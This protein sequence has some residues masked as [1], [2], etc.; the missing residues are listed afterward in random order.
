MKVITY[1]D[2]P[3]F[4]YGKLFRYTTGNVDA[5]FVC[6]G[7]DLTEEQQANLSISGIE[8]KEIDGDEFQNKMQFLKFKLMK[9]EMTD[10]GVSFIDFDTVLVKDWSHVFAD[11]F[12][13]GITVRNS[14]VKQ[15]ILRAYTNGG[16]MF[17]KNPSV[18]DY[19]IEVM[20]NGGAD[21]IPEYDEIFKSLEEG[22][23]EH[24]THKRE[25]LRWWV[26]QVFISSLALR[27]FRLTGEKGVKDR[28]FFEFN[29]FKVGLFSCDK[30]NRLDPTPAQCRKIMSDKSAHILHLKSKGR[31]T[32]DAMEKAVV[33]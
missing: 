28:A 30:Y 27:Y 3:Y 24:K 26:D 2:S 4:K 31:E 20:E 10:E 15:G 29:G 33:R 6:Y 7:P 17:C 12:D 16:V 1:S 18:C 21:D 22:R 25:T 32:L 8:H 14:Y 11:D 23:P 9:D 19:A 13:I 5:D